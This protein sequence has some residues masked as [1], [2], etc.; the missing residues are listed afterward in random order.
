MAD[1]NN[2]LAGRLPA[3][4]H[5][6]LRELDRLV[7]RWQVSGSFLEGLLEFEWMEGGFFLVQR[8]EAHAGDRR[9]AGIEYIGFDEETQTLRSHYM[10]VHGAN[11]AY[12]WRIDG[13]SITIWFGDEGSESFFSARFGADGDSYAG[14]WQWPGG[15]YSAS[16]RRVH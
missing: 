9:I 13:D 1:N 7:G 15:G 4:P 14:A 8:V 3:E 5:P 10:D 16:A 11:F 12:T 6:R 2:H